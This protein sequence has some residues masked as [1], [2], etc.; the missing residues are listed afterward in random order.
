METLEGV[1]LWAISRV[2]QDIRAREWLGLGR[3]IVSPREIMLR[4]YKKHVEV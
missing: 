1:V 4:Q 2:P 3:K